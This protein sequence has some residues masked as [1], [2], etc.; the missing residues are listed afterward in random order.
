MCLKWSL[1]WSHSPTIG[2]VIE[3]HPLIY[4]MNQSC[5]IG[6]VVY[7]WVYYIVYL[8]GGA[9]C[10]SWK[11]MEWKST[12]PG[13]HPIYEMKSHKIPWFETTNQLW[14][15]KHMFTC[16]RFQCCSDDEDVRWS[17][18]FTNHFKLIREGSKTSRRSTCF[19][20]RVL[21][22]FIW[23]QIFNFYWCLP[24]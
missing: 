19:C 22:C 2:V 23:C 12:L 11:M 13:W 14:K 7:Y 4:P 10:P 24:W 6:M 16:L 3:N 21:Y 9:M 8:V 5:T 1:K 17:T 15:K 20:Y 18:G